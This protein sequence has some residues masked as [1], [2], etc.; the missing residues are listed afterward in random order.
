MTFSVDPFFF[1]RYDAKN[2][3]CLHH[4]AEVWK[5]VT[6][7]D[8]LDKLA[9]VL[10]GL[11]RSHVKAF[12][13][14]ERAQAPCLALMRQRIGGTLHVGVYLKGRILHIT[15]RGVEFQPA[16]VVGARYTDLRFYR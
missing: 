7:E 14:L 12:A 6:G 11:S 13:R 2:Y 1:R 4:A 15:P 10:N 16:C 5:A 9:G 3:H 8:I